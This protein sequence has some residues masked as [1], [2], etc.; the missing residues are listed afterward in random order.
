MFSCE[1]SECA[2]GRWRLMKNNMCRYEQMEHSECL[3][4]LTELEKLSEKESKVISH[5]PSFL[6]G[7]RAACLRLSEGAAVFHLVDLLMM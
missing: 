7:C 2:A 1:R 5:L 6:L 4:A 3:R